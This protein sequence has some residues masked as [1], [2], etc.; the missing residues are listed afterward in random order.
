VKVLLTGGAGYIGSHA[1]REFLAAGHEV[2]VLDDLS[3][4]HREAV[5]EGVPL[6]VGDWG[7]G[8]PA[9]GA[10][11]IDAMVHFAGVLDVGVSPPSLQVLEHQRQKGIALLRDSRDRG[12]EDHRRHLRDLRRSGARRIDETHPQEPINPHGQSKRAFER[13][14]KDL[15]ERAC[16]GLWPWSFNAPGVIPTASLGE[17]HDPEIHLIP[18]AIDAAL[19]RRPA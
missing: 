7:W 16:C 8:D 9:Q 13:A 5:P 15:A 19:G 3:K 2:S 18:L 12:A 11:G 4:G 6:H 10:A 14:L 17:D 1:V